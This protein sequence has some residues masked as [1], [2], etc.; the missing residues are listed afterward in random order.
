MEKIKIHNQEDFASMRKAGKVAAQILDLAETII[1]PGISTGEL[2]D[3]CHDEIIKK[4]GIPATLNYKGFP[5]SMCTSVNHVVC[6]GIPSYE[7]ILKEGDI[8]NVD[9]TVIIDGWHGDTSRM[10]FVGNATA[11]SAIKAR[12]LCDITYEAMM[13]GID[14]IKPGEP[15]NNIG[16]AIEKHAKKHG[17]STVEDYCGHGIGKTFHAPP[18]V[19]HY[20]SKFVD[21]IIKP[22][23]FFTVEPMLNIGKKHTKLLQDDW[24]VVTK[25]K[26]LSAQWEHTIGVTE[27]GYEIFTVSK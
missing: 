19:L 21:T 1:E 16:K 18:N 26:S 8:I 9:V 14:E 4:G 3:I 5:K 12:T 25:D 10:Y 27:T 23:M 15:L 6:H 24:T 22:G 11:P 17:Y 2:N 7:K 13:L 20:D